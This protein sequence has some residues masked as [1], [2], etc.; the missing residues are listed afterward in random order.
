MGLFGPKGPGGKV[1]SW[2]TKTRPEGSTRVQTDM[3]QQNVKVVTGPK[4]GDHYFYNP[5]SYK[6]G[7]KK[8]TD[9]KK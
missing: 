9:K 3:R 7:F 5:K 2:S 8:E 6:S 1:V 4:A